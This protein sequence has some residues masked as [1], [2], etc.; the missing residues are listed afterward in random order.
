MDLIARGS[1]VS[2]VGLT[3]LWTRSSLKNMGLILSKILWKLE[4][5]LELTKLT[6]GVMLITPE[7]GKSVF[8]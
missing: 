6:S 5:R 4:L 3:I 2:A 1:F 8:Y 7:I